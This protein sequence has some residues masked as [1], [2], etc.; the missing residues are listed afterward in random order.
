MTSTD[1]DTKCV[2]RKSAV[3]M[4]EWGDW[5]IVLEALA[6]L[7]WILRISRCPGILLIRG[8]AFSRSMIFG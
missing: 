1:E 8:L 5:G 3:C 2:L 6:E 7:S 4:T